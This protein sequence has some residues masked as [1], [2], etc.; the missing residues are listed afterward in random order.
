MSFWKSLFGKPDKPVSPK[1]FEKDISLPLN[2]SSVPTKEAIAGRLRDSGAFQNDAIHWIAEML[3]QQAA[4][5]A[6]WDAAVKTVILAGEN[7]PADKKGYVGASKR[8]RIGLKFLDAMS[9]KDFSVAS[10]AVFLAI[11]GASSKAKRE[12]SLAQMKEAGITHVRLISS[13][14]ERDCSVVRAL[15]GEVMQID[16]AKLPLPGCDAEYCRCTFAPV[17]EFD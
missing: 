1:A 11:Q 7:A 13:R 14:D 15:E 9:G 17:I 6:S 5:G 8:K 12:F 4:K 3:H 2:A 10:R 16:D